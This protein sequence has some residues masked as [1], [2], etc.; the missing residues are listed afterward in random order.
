MLRYRGYVV[1][2]KVLR[3]PESVSRNSQPA[4]LNPTSRLLDPSGAMRQPFEV[5]S[6]IQI[7]TRSPYGCLKR[8]IPPQIGIWTT[9]IRH[10]QQ[11]SYAIFNFLICQV[12]KPYSIKEWFTIFYIALHDQTIISSQLI[13]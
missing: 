6:L 4:K 11:R 9:V 12:A 13:N 3:P 1:N 8:Y 7:Y 5:P 2:A 10:I